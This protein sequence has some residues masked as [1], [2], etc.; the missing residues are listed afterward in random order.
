MFGNLF[1]MKGDDDFLVNPIPG[2]HFANSRKTARRFFM[3]LRAVSI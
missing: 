1:I 2:F 3:I